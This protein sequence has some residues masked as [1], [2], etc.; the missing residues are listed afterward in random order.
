MEVACRKLQKISNFWKCYCSNCWLYFER[1][2]FPHWLLDENN[3][4]AQNGPMQS[5][6]LC[7]SEHTIWHIKFVLLA[8]YL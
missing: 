1:R 2:W 7:W 4:G 5:E 3:Y 8:Y 6:I